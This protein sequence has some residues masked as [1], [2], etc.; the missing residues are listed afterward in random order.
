MAE[1][2]YLG[3]TELGSTEQ[4]VINQ[5]R[6]A[7]WMVSLPSSNMMGYN[8]EAVKGKEVIAVQIKDHK[9]PVKVPQVE[10]FLNFFDLPRSRRFTRGLLIAANGFTHNALTYYSNVNTQ[11]VRLAVLKEDIVHWFRF[12]DK[13][14]V[15][16]PKEPG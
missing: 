10:R 13:P 14:L 2:D 7:G 4:T 5:L 12:A 3:N 15:T 16:P 8:F 11:K 1:V 9:T 6:K